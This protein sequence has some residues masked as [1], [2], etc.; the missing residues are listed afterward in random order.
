LATLAA[1]GVSAT[2]RSRPDVTDHDLVQAVRAGDDHA[3]ERLYHR[4]HRRIS[5]YIFG[6]VHDHGRAEDLT[7]EVFVSAL[8]R[9]RQ[10]DRPIAFKAWIYEIAK[11]ACI[12][13]FRRSRRTEEVS[14]DAEEGLAPADHGKLASISPSPDAA[15]EGKQQLDDLCGAFGGLS[16]AH[17]QILVMRELEGLSYREIGDRLGMSRPSVESTLFRARRRLS[18][19]YDELRTGERCLRIQEIVGHAAAGA[20][21]LRD[22]RRVGSHISHCQPCR[23]HAVMAGVDVGA[24]AR[25]PVRAKIAAFLPLPAFLR[26]RW[27][28]GDGGGGASDAATAHAAQH[29]PALAQMSM[30]AAQYGEPSMA[31]WVKATAVATAVAIA[32]VGAGAADHAV[33]GGKHHDPP[34]VRATPASTASGAAGAA[35]G[36][37]GA[38]GGARRVVATPSG[39]AVSSG[40]SGGGQHRSGTGGSSGGSGATGFSGAGGGGATGGAGAGSGASGSAPAAS[41]GGGGSGESAS[42]AAAGGGGSTSTASKP[43][44]GGSNGSGAA[45]QAAG[46][47]SG[48]ADAVTDPAAGA[49][50]E[51]STPPPL[52]DPNLGALTQ[53]ASTPPPQSAGQAVSGVTDVVGNTVGGQAGDAVKQTGAAVGSTVDRVTQ[54]VTGA[55]GGLLGGK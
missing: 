26:K 32:G 29:G 9:M 36:G 25:R 28:G 55:V 5:A 42:S 46:A 45:Q 17:H 40:G 24:L 51:A 16:D 23:K 37:G 12:D 38:T 39:T 4:Y 53:P 13:A 27:L 6:M 20:L 18:E 44:G 10:T 19:E 21:G 33:R 43:A 48:A 50:G 30:A 1:P 49:T 8:R 11:N 47:A 7:Q 3:F 14:I 34:I 41:G 54:G 31:G 22:Q 52:V 15:V 35:A 2:A